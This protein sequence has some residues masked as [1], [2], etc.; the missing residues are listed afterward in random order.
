LFREET[1]RAGLV[2]ILVDEAHVIAQ[3]AADFRKDYG[4]LEQLRVVTGTEIPWGLFS[5]TL[6]TSVFNLC[7]ESVRLGETRPFWGLDLGSNRSNL[8]QWVRPMEY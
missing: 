6:P 8:A 7:F 4:E 1:F 2:A 5:A 3:W